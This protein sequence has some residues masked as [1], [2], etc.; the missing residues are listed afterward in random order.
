MYDDVV[1]DDENPFPGQLFNQPTKKGTPG[2]DVYHGVKKDYT[3]KDVTAKN[4]LSIITGD[5]QSMK[6]IG[7]G[8]V[9]E[10]T[11]EDRVFI[12]FVDHG[13]V[14]LIAFPEQP[15]LYKKDLQSAL[16]QMHNSSMYKELVFYLEACESGSMFKGFPKGLNAY[17]TTAA[18]G[19]ESSWGTYCAPNDQVDGTNLNTCL[20][21]LFSV[22][23]MEDSDGHD[24]TKETL[25]EQYTRVKK[26]T[27]KSH[28]LQFGD[29]DDIGPEYVAEFI[30]ND[31]GH[32]VVVEDSTTLPA[33][34]Q[35]SGH[36]DSRDHELNRFYHKYART[37]DTKDAKRLIAE[38]QD[39]I[40]HR[41]RFEA[42][43]LDVMRGDKKETNRLMNSNTYYTPTHDT[44][45]KLVNLAYEKYCH[46]YSDY[47]RKFFFC[48][49]RDLVKIKHMLHDFLIDIYIILCHV[50][51][52][53]CHVT[54]T[55]VPVS[56]TIILF[57]KY[58]C[59]STSVIDRYLPFRYIVKFVRVMVN[60]CEI[61]DGDS[62]R[63]VQAVNSA[64]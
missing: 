4:F 57:F 30:G 35:S 62:E 17:M 22:N 2:K 48:D 32:L 39:R 12:N 5:K 15:Y 28:V 7:T 49:S 24:T 54:R 10:S 43:V 64:C 40:Q 8:R 25:N 18:N 56:L 16:V 21:D 31:D 38:I 42:I 33:R 3:G 9:L 20:G 47:S 46:G 37:E 50:H 61:T 6:D 53:I 41:E 29:V 13:G 51:D 45:Q 1:N 36:F 59:L 60:L 34:T 27:N 58:P 26:L 55:I 23:W 44:C 63:I 14:G 11:K 52:I 19:K